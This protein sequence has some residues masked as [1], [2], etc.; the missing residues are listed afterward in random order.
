MP[1]TRARTGEASTPPSCEASA[2][3]A[4]GSLPGTRS[5]ACTAALRTCRPPGG[6][7]PRLRRARSVL[8]DASSSEG[9][10]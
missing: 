7:L 6:V 9:I 8:V 3:I 1:P 4:P 10:G 2:V 5:A